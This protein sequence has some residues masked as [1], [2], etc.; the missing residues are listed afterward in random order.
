MSFFRKAKNH[1]HERVYQD[2]IKCLDLYN[3][4]VL[5][6]DDLMVLVH[7]LL[8]DSPRVYSEFKNLTGFDDPSP[9]MVVRSLLCMRLH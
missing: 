2:L 4:E 5:T 7:D 3:S 6:Q 8:E 1:L 9:G